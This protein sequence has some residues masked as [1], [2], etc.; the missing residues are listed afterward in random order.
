MQF[1]VMGYDGDDEFAMDRR[2]AAREAHLKLFGEM[3]ANGLFLFGA[4]LLSD[5]GKMVGSMI[6]CDFPSQQELEAQWL[7]REPYVRGDV[8]R[9]IEIKRAAVPPLLLQK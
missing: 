2:M 3:H 9:R 1:I 7:A 8:W 4:A 6:V 5:D